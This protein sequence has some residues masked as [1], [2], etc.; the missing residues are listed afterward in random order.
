MFVIVMLKTCLHL[1]LF[2]SKKYFHV[3]TVI[4]YGNIDVVV[5]TCMYVLYVLVGGRILG[6]FD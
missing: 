1:T 4:D 3:V 5:P 6:I 2:A